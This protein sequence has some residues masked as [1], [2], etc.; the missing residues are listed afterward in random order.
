M[1]KFLFFTG[2]ASV[3]S[4]ASSGYGSR[5]VSSLTLTSEDSVSIRSN[6]ENTES[7][8][9][10]LHKLASGETCQSQS[11]DSGVSVTNLKPCEQNPVSDISMSNDSTSDTA[12][13]NV[14]SSPSPDPLVQMCDND[15]NTQP[16]HTEDKSNQKNLKENGQ[17]IVQGCDMGRSEEQLAVPV[18][19]D[20]DLY[21]MNA[22]E[23]L[24]KLG[25]EDEEEDDDIEDN[26]KIIEP[27]VIEPKVIEPKVVEPEVFEPKVNG[28]NVKKP[29]ADQGLRNGHEKEA[30]PS[31]T[32]TVPSVKEKTSKGKYNVMKA[33]SAISTSTTSQNKGEKAISSKGNKSQ[34]DKTAVSSNKRKGIGIR[35][36]PM[37]VGISPKTEMI[38]RA[39]Q[40]EVECNMDK[41]NS[42]DHLHGT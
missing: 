14:I 20:C 17:I 35:P 1:L 31:P 18:D 7:V 5:A 41:N 24:E 10:H 30:V 34:G 21:S 25:M 9:H 33:L 42:E 39:W 28:S 36:R 29:V 6:E 19:E 15:E 32:Q 37:T 38:T 13:Q 3:P 8:H 23:E 27:K 40:E 11:D 4:A 12:V 22:T 26:A 16:C 2:G